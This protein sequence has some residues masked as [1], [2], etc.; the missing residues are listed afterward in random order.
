M[1]TGKTLDE[2]TGAIVDAA[3]KLHQGLGPGL[4]ES[5]YESLLAQELGRRGFRAERQKPIS[6]EFDGLCFEEGFRIDLLVEGAVVVELKSVEAVSSVHKKQ[7]LTYL[8]LLR[9]PVGL[10]V[11]FGAAT[12]REGLSRIVNHLS[13]VESPH[14]RVNC[15]SQDRE[16]SA[17]S[18]SLRGA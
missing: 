14:L 16:F 9:L 8:R 13:P 15:A 7:L 10:L 18:A 17:P 11:N 4:L 6:F 3:V 1:E 5:V 2:I 12:L